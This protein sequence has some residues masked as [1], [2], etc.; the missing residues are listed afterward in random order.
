[1]TI[2][3][4]VLA[5]WFA[6][7]IIASGVWIAFMRGANRPRRQPADVPSSPAPAGISK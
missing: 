4:L 1:M 7:S 5:S 2:L 3:L 6:L